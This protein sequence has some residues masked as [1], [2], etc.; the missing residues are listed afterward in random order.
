[1]IMENIFQKQEI[2]LPG[3]GFV[4]KINI[5]WMIDSDGLD[6]ASNMDYTLS[7]TFLTRRSAHKKR[8]GHKTHYYKTFSDVEYFCYCPFNYIT[9]LHFLMFRHVAYMHYIIPDK[10]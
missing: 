2:I 6:N 4:G 5:R 1:M 9:L 3:T 7:L 8:S 10:H